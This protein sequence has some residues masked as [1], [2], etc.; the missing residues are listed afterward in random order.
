MRKMRLLV[1]VRGHAGPVQQLQVPVDGILVS[2]DARAV[3]VWSLQQ[4]SLMLRAGVPATDGQRLTNVAVQNGLLLTAE[5]NLVCRMW[6]AARLSQRW[7]VRCRVDGVRAPLIALSPSLSHPAVVLAGATGRTQVKVLNAESGHFEHEYELRWQW[8]RTAMQTSAVQFSA[9]GTYLALGFS[10]GEMAFMQVHHS[11]HPELTLVEVASGGSCHYESVNLI[12]SAHTQVLFVSGSTSEKVV[13]MWALTDKHQFHGRRLLRDSQLGSNA[14]ELQAAVWTADDRHLL[15]AHTHTT[16]LS[17]YE[18]RGEEGQPPSATFARELAGEARCDFAGAVRVA[19]AAHPLLPDMVA[20]SVSSGGGAI[21]IWNI[22]NGLKVAVLSVESSEPI[23]IVWSAAPPPPC[24]STSASAA[25]A[26]SSSS[27]FSLPSTSA[28]ASSS[29]HHSSHS[30]SLSSS[31]SSSQF[32][33]VVGHDNGTISVFGVASEDDV[34]EIRCAVPPQQFLSIDTEAY[35]WRRDDGGQL[36]EASTAA[37]LEYYRPL[38]LVDSQGY[39][40]RRESQAAAFGRAT[41]WN[42][43]E[44]QADVEGIRQALPIDERFLSPLGMPVELP[45]ANSRP[46]RALPPLGDKAAKGAAEGHQLKVSSE[47]QKK[48][49]AAAEAKK[50]GSGSSISSS[51]SGTGSGSSGTGSGSSGSKFTITRMSRRSR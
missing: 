48:R 14:G 32:C 39:Y 41:N 40:L 23:S 50:Q 29:S 51:S 30:S 5:S 18:V 11:L 17:V 2:R 33:L 47:E 22:E 46:T 20:T 35:T 44:D 15:L 19:V 28:S 10:S 1:A 16:S 8:Q 24:T 31:S 34:N 27:A 21:I 37:P 12:V 42:G 26:L 38:R 4:Q 49:K 36:C 45:P 25:S 43:E 7:A 3:K 9:A 13:I 6:Q